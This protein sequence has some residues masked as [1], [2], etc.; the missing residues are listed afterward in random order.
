ML[1]RATRFE[2][3]GYEVQ[4]RVIARL[5]DRIEEKKDNLFLEIWYYVQVMAGGDRRGL[6]LEKNSYGEEG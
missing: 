1:S 4:Y 2:D 5:A 6:P 3:A